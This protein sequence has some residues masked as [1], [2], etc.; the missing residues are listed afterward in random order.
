M[1]QISPFE[2]KYLRMK[3]SVFMFLSILIFTSCS[4]K[5]EIGKW[6]DIIKLSTKNVE[7][8]SEMD[9]VTI[10]TEGDW[11]WVENI[12]FEDSTFL[13]H[14]R[15]DINLE[16]DYYRITEDQFLVEKRDKHT[17]FVKFNENNTGKDRVMNICLEAGDYFDYVKIMQAGN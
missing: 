13:L 1:G 15:D 9:S 10:T 12:S 17:L 4:D 6:S 2:T 7:F 5:E 16:S 3:K 8:T 11:W 14:E